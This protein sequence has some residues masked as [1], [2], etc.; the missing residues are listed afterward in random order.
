MLTDEMKDEIEAENMIV[1]VPMQS[2][3]MSLLK[4]N[5]ETQTEQKDEKSESNSTQEEGNQETPSPSLNSRRKKLV[6]Q[7]PV[8]VPG[9]Q[10][11]P[12]PVKKKKFDSAETAPTPP[13]AEPVKAG[14]TKIQEQT[15]VSAFSLSLGNEE[16][17]KSINVHQT[18]TTSAAVLSKQKNII[19]V[20]M[21]KRK[22]G[23]LYKGS[24]GS[25]MFTV[26]KPRNVS[27]GGYL[28]EGFLNK[29]KGRVESSGKQNKSK[30]GILSKP[31]PI[32]SR[33]RKES[34]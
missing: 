18:L 20:S 7:R 5:A 6:K 10:Q 34:M 33:K 12:P 2:S 8:K 26:K 15:T 28:S 21:I 29:L 16:A 3:A 1:Q 22:T 30:E 4:Q 32:P 9:K 11:P 13:F 31:Q 17:K 19:D 24:F 14:Q 23:A 25:K 27:P